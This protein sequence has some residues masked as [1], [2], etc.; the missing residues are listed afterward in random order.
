[1]AAQEKKEQEAQT[2]K[3]SKC[4]AETE[5]LYGYGEGTCLECA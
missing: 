2:K 1:M 3:C 4:G 5:E